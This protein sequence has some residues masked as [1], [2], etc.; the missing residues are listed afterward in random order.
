MAV[1]VLCRALD[2]ARRCSSDAAATSCC[3]RL[4]LTAAGARALGGRQ[5]QACGCASTT[6]GILSQF[7]GYEQLEE[8]DW[9]GYRERYGDISRLD[10]IL[11]A[12]GDTPTATRSPSRP[13]C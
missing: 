12:E 4:G 3:E 10:R 13:T 8:L 11:E 5:P 9:D 1:W 6:D 7:E 2:A